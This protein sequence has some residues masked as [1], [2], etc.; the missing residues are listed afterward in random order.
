LIPHVGEFSGNQ[1]FDSTFVA[2]QTLDVKRLQATQ[3]APGVTVDDMREVAQPE[4]IKENKRMGR[5]QSFFM[6]YQPSLQVQMLSSRIQRPSPRRVS[7]GQFPNPSLPG[8]IA[9]DGTE[10]VTALR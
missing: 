7:Q 3:V 6:H 4:R 2:G 5:S 1:L 8:V 9:N 10:G